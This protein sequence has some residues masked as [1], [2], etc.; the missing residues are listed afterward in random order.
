MSVLPDDEGTPFEDDDLSPEAR[1]AQRPKSAGDD[2]SDEPFG[3]DVGSFG[4]GG[5][6]PNTPGEDDSEGGWQSR[7]DSRERSSKRPLSPGHDDSDEPFSE[8]GDSSGSAGTRPSTPGKDDSDVSEDSGEGRAERPK[9]PGKDDSENQGRPTGKPVGVRPTREGVFDDDPPP[10]EEVI[11]EGPVVEGPS[12]VQVPVARPKQSSSQPG[13]GRRDLVT[14]AFMAIIAAG[15]V[16]AVVRPTVPT[17]RSLKDQ[18]AELDKVEDLDERYNGFNLLLNRLPKKALTPDSLKELDEFE[19]RQKPES[20]IKELIR[21]AIDDFK[22]QLKQKSAFRVPPLRDATQ[23]VPLI[24]SRTPVDSVRDIL[25]L[26]VFTWAGNLDTEFPYPD[27]KAKEIVDQMIGRLPDVEQG[28]VNKARSIYGNS[29]DRAGQLTA[30]KSLL[31][32]LEPLVSSIGGEKP[33]DQDL[34]VKAEILNWYTGLLRKHLDNHRV[35][36][37]VHNSAIG[38]DH[39]ETARFPSYQQA[40]R[41]L[42]K[43]QHQLSQRQREM[44]SRALSLVGPPPNPDNKGGNQRFARQTDLEDVAKKSDLLRTDLTPLA[45]KTDLTPLARKTDLVYPEGLDKLLKMVPEGEGKLA[46]KKDVDAAK[47]G[48]TAFEMVVTKLTEVGMKLETGKT[49]DS[50]TL[51]GLKAAIVEAKKYFQPGGNS[52]TPEDWT[53]LTATIAKLESLLPTTE[54]AS[55]GAASGGVND[56]Q[57]NT[58]GTA[59][60][61]EQSAVE[62]QTPGATKPTKTQRK[63]ATTQDLEDQADR[64]I[65][66]INPSK[67]DKTPS[68]PAYS[69]SE[70]AAALDK[71]Q[72]AIG[73][74]T[75]ES[76]GFNDQQIAELARLIANQ[77]PPAPPGPP[78][79]NTQPPFPSIFPFQCEPPGVGTLP[80]IQRPAVVAVV[81]DVGI[82]E[83]ALNEDLAA[84][85]FE[86]GYNSLFAAKGAGFASAIDHLRKA[87]GHAP[88]RALYR[89][90]LGLAYYLAGDVATATAH[91]REAAK[92]E[93]TSQPGWEFFNRFERVQN[94][95][96]Q[97]WRSVRRD[98]RAA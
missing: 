78:G 86:S 11:V 89:H 24:G 20:P 93:G 6:R 69:D 64:V 17:E 82:P 79:G 39:S 71:I 38:Q 1:R 34:V 74:I 75:P 77:M 4:G 41:R 95:A 57:P 87:C 52:Q 55:P 56:T 94:G 80:Y 19:A 49:V 65:A 50:D 97:W 31:N 62:G 70:I 85:H 43:I 29:K 18:L 45:H 98:A 35:Q 46:T 51:T 73:D 90:F 32:F 66:A 14:W 48:N 23:A 7:E 58:N 81:A 59:T 28:V 37:E 36:A 91:V 8:S 68:K 15:V 42:S 12:K 22:E 92:L 63:L 54:V 61:T 88:K 84:E 27:D 26:S 47:P 2:D 5:K 76:G 67:N 10:F 83:L 9:S 53:K 25:A 96:R 13:I 30:A 33:D 21:I 72:G 16:W 44:T 40:E 60:E 3:D